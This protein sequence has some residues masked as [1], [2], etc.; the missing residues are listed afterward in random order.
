MIEPALAER[1]TRLLAFMLRHEPE[2]F[3]VDV[4]AHGFADVNEV[5]RAL[6]ERLGGPLSLEELTAAV[7][8]G[9]RRRYEIREGRIRAL[10]GHSIEVEP[11]PESRP[12]EV[13]HIAVPTRDVERARRFG[14]RGG[15]RRFLHLAVDA[16]DALAAGRRTAQEYTLIR[17]L[18]IDAWEQGVH[19]YDRG[20]L[21]LA[22]ELPT[23]LIEVGEARSDG[24]PARER[25]GRHGR[26]E[27]GRRDGPHGSEG[28]SRGRGRRRGGRG[29]SGHGGSGGF[30]GREPAMPREAS[31][32]HDAHE[33]RDAHDHREAG[34]QRD[35]QPY[36]EAGH[37]RGADHHREAGQHRGADH[38]RDGGHHREGGAQREP[39]ESREAHAPAARPERD[40][41]RAPER[42][43]P[44]ERARPAAAERRE[45]TP[46]PPRRP[47]SAPNA[48]GFGLGIFDEQPRPARAPAAEP[49]RPPAPAPAP[50]PA[51][52]RGPSFGAG[53]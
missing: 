34:H 33:Q 43:A 4:D 37:H 29:R 2:Q 15:R 50:P 51:A 8:G 20:S 6:E 7:E 12:P 13:L 17:V 52:P 21:W 30:D 35:A 53:L 48:G 41:W 44:A 9:D 42:G 28:G 11:G 40:A 36:R 3:D 1:I 46:E 49:A 32:H 31:E 10:Y 39:R 25:E 16:E 26:D 23:H 24:E 47:A 19:F 45:L 14:L 38:H 27:G 5:L 18:A 22:E